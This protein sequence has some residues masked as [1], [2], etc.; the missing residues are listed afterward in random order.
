MSLK[1]YIINHIVHDSISDNVASAIGG[2]FTANIMLSIID[3]THI[4]S[5]VLFSFI[6]GISGLAGKLF[7][8]YIYDKYIKNRI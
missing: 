8:Q 1:D 3:V 4:I 5:V 7:L 2:I 6:G